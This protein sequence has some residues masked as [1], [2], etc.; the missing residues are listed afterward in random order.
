MNV[1][2]S[3]RLIV[4]VGIP[5]AALFLVVMWVAA[6]RSYR[7]VLDQTE[8]T[9]RVV[10]RQYAARLNTVLSRAAKIPEMIALDVE[11]GK[12]A[13]TADLEIYLREVLKR[14]PESYGSCIAFEPHSFDPARQYYAPYYYWMDG[15]PQF[16]QLGN[17][18]YNYFKWDWYK[19][20]KEAGRAL[21]SE[22]YFDEGGGNTIM[23]TYSVPIRKKDHQFWGIATVD[24][25]MSQLMAHVGAVEGGRSSY[26]FIVS[27][28][29]R[30]LTHPDKAQIMRGMIQE[31]NP[32]L[33]RLMISGI[34][35]FLRTP[36]P[37][38]RRDSLVAFA[39]VANGEFSIAIVY[40]ESEVMSD[41]VRLH[42]E[43]LTLALLGLVVMFVA[44]I[45]IARSISSPITQLSHAAQQVAAGHFEVN[46]DTRAPVAEVR[47]LTLAFN[48][49]ARDL[50]MRMQEL[51]YTT[52]IKERLE[53]ELSAA[54]S[55][56]MSLLPKTFPAFPERPEIDVHAVVR[57]AREVGGDFYDFYFI[58]AEHL[59]AVIADVSGKGIPAALYMAVTKTL[60][61][62]NASPTLAPAEIMA[63]VNRELCE[64]R[65]TGMFV[66]LLFA[67]LHTATGEL[68]L[69]NAGHH[70]PLLIDSSGAVI[71]VTGQSPA[72]GLLPDVSFEIISRRLDPGDTLF[73]FTDGVTEAL[74][75]GRE[76]FS[77]PR[78]HEMLRD[79]NTQAVNEV[80]RHVVEE[81]SNF[82]AAREQSDDISVLALRWISPPKNL[83]RAHAHPH[84]AASP[85]VV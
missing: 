71:P 36:E 73:F 24:M 38:T 57:P 54:R 64:K 32:Q 53:G 9:T 15:E 11:G 83:P 77:T 12:Y 67:I 52:T 31:A 44:L 10:A 51:R 28:Q 27:K 50:Q 59:C 6:Q 1:R 3:T 63:R 41:A 23:T 72:L 20:P 55:I 22:P 81:V 33:G 39:P 47:N 61:K 13:T 46:L 48:K 56:Q 17:P 2:L 4:R 34:D 74:N 65:D 7:R 58:D 84:A 45:F 82:C 40:P 66:T 78:L 30:F 16:V 85:L 49:M 62:A 26:S 29:G 69:C 80:T 25:A 18:E 60:L 8:R 79:A 43:L 76:F 37:A 68:K 19:L 35:G 21:W 14:S 5:G 70:A 42:S 75:S